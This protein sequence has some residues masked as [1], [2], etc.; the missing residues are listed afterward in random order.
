MSTFNQVTVLRRAVEVL[1]RDFTDKQRKN[2][3]KTGE[4]MPDGSF[5]IGNVEDLHSAVLL[6]HNAADPSEA[7][8]HIMRRA[9][10]LGAEAE[11]PPAW[12]AGKKKPVKKSEELVADLIQI[13]KDW[14][15][16]N[17]D[18]KGMGRT[19]YHYSMASAHKEKADTFYDKRTDKADAQGD[20]H[21]DAAN[22]HTDAARTFEQQGDNGNARSAGDLAEQAT[23][24]AGAVKI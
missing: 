3:A 1:K 23:K 20:R 13:Q 12:G 19:S 16:W 17:E 15:Q 14:A 18:H 5:P 21:R 2:A 11:L 6:M 7:K 4:A 8:D 22:A 9:T 10:A 24:K